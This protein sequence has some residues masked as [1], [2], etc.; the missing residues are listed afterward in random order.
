[1]TSC[2]TKKGYSPPPGDAQASES[3]LYSTNEAEKKH[4]ASAK[5]IFPGLEQKHPSSQEGSPHLEEA[6]PQVPQD[7]TSQQQ[8]PRK[9][10]QKGFPPPEEAQP[11]GQQVVADLKD[12]S[13][14]NPGNSPESENQG[15]S[16]S[17]LIKDEEPT[18]PTM[19]SSQNNS[20]EWI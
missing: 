1:M 16:K 6:I 4:S 3:H 19:T 8:S 11:Q 2:L 20:V 10:T 18:V 9:S 15:E 14:E 17:N 12:P 7:F 5:V 13:L